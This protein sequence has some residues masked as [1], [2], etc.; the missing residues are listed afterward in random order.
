MGM[1]Q[2]HL[3]DDHTYSTEAIGSHLTIHNSLHHLIHPVGTL[4]KTVLGESIF[5][6][7]PTFKWAVYKSSIFVLFLQMSLIQY[8]ALLHGIFSQKR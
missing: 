7:G 6:L 5:S 4:V 1:M 2:P 3:L 8:F